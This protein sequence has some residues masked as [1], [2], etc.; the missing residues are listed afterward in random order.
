MNWFIENVQYYTKSEPQKPESYRVQKYNC[1]NCIHSQSS[2]N[3]LYCIKLNRRKN[4]KSRVNPKKGIC[5]NHEWNKE[6]D[7][8]ID[9]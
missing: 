6:L 2:F 4:K 9:F 7:I 1:K 3:K 5:D 8:Y